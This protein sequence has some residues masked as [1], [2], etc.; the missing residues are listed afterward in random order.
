LSPLCLAHAC[1]R[2]H[3]SRR[4]ACRRSFQYLLVGLLLCCGLH[5]ATVPA[6]GD[7]QVKNLSTDEIV[8]RLM[9][10]NAR[11]AAALHEYQGIRTYEVDYKGF[12]TG[13][14]HARMVIAMNYKAPHERTLSIVSEDGSKLLL[15]HVLHKLIQTELETNGNKEHVDS[16]LSRANYRFQLLGTETKDGRSCYVLQVIPV[17]NNK[18]LYRGKIWVDG[19]E[20]AVVHI[21]AQPAKSPSFWISQTQIEHQYTKVADFWLPMQN[22]STSRVRFGGTALLTIEYKDYEV[23]P[24]PQN[25]DAVTR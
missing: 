24:G 15:D 23:N 7:T 16:D 19:Q 18:L 8:D 20:Y 1:F 5:F 6:F 17:R 14:K 9:S 21:E 12:P 2:I 4:A 11:R 3:D 13:H 25:S 22:R 10:N